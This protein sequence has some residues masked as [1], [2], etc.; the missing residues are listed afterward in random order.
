MLSFKRH[1]LLPCLLLVVCTVSSMYNRFP[2]TLTGRTSAELSENITEDNHIKRTD[3]VDESGQV[4]LAVDK[5]YATVVH[6]KDKKKR[7]IREEYLDENGHPIM[8]PGGYSVIAR[9]YEDE[10]HL[11]RIRYLDTSGHPVMNRSGYAEILRSYNDIGKAD[12]DLYFDL[13][14]R[15]SR[16]ADGYYGIR[17]EYNKDKRVS[18]IW[19]LDEEGQPVMT[20]NGYACVRREYNEEGK[21]A[22]VSYFNTEGEAVSTR[23]RQHGYLYED[24]QRTYVDIDGNAVFRLDKLL[25]GRQILVIAAGIVLM[26]LAIRLKGGYKVVVLLAYLVFIFFMT[27]WHREWGD[28]QGNFKLFWSYQQFFTR[29]SL[30]QE[31]LNNIWLFVPLGALIYKPGTKYWMIIILVSVGIETVQ[32]LTGTG[33]CEFDDIISN[34]LGGFI[35]W[36][37]AAGLQ[38]IWNRT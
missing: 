13:E 5:G 21:L 30:R 36:L 33:L 29:P 12:T 31:I 22:K 20:S 25:H 26:L 3:Y 27:F 24:G 2:K 14:E 8:L 35:G 16:V 28:S 11:V 1:L 19:Y 9:T 7:T 32:Y 37:A 17:R 18:A 23:S 4:T 6:T 15:P 38:D 10:N 34:T